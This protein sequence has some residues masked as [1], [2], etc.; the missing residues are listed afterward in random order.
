MNL[1]N[2]TNKLQLSADLVKEWGESALPNGQT[3]AEIF[4]Y[5]SISFW[6][7]VSVYIALYCVPP[8]LSSY[9]QPPRYSKLIKTYLRWCKYKIISQKNIYIRENK[10]CDRPS[11]PVYMF[12][13][14]QPYFYNDT[15]QPI[16]NNMVNDK[17]VYLVNLYDNLLLQ[18]R[19]QQIVTKGGT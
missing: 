9:K 11:K 4:T 16:V 3:L 12:L 7:V 5:E 15:L 19:F 17:E 10:Q 8:A 13:G 18:N 2:F 14:F 6:D 1:D